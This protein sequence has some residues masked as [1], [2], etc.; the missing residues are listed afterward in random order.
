MKKSQRQPSRPALKEDF[1]PWI[2]SQRDNNILILR[3]KSTTKAQSFAHELTFP[4]ASHVDFSLHE[5]QQSSDIISTFPAS[6]VWITSKKYEKCY[7]RYHAYCIN[8]YHT[9]ELK[10]K[11]KPEWINVMLQ[12]YIIYYDYRLHITTNNKQEIKTDYLFIYFHFLFP[13]WK[14]NLGMFLFKKTVTRE[15]WK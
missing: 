10:K 8:K 1:H 7:L 15:K 6:I 2:S 9:G 5:V 3:Y 4:K 13:P 14:E 11:K 12:Q